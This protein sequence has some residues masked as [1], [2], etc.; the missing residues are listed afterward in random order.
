MRTDGLGADRELLSDRLVREPLGEEVEHLGLARRELRASYGPDQAETGVGGVDVAAPVE[1]GA[2]GA[3][4][5]DERRLLQDDTVG[6]GFKELGDLRVARVGRVDEDAGSGHGLPQPL[7]ELDSAEA[8]HP[9][10]DEGDV[11]LR[12]G[13]ELERLAAVGGSA[14]EVEA[15]CLQVARDCGDERRMIVGD[16]TAGSAHAASRSCRTRPARMSANSAPLTT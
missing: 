8:R 5:V 12:R 15:V 13:G 3:H 6:T 9:E 1:D 10:V 4:E 14:D 11:G 7:D 2:Q 16:E